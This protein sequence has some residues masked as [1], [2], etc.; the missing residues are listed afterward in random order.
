MNLKD[1]VSKVSTETSVPAAQV[2]K[3]A[4]ALLEALRV[5]VQSGENFTSPRLNI[6]AVTTKATVKVDKSGNEIN[7]PEM[8]IGRM[9]PKEPKP[10]S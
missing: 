10:K 4:N 9:V 2:R 1:L 5:N 6:R 8:K 7:V 3:V